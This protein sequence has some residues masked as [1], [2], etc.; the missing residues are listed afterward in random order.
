M[1]IINVAFSFF[2]KQIFRLHFILQ[3]NTG[4]QEKATL[5]FLNTIVFMGRKVYI[6]GT[7]NDEKRSRG[8]IVIRNPKVFLF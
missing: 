4:K 8:T 2:S 1:N 7:F 5:L 3:N 6:K